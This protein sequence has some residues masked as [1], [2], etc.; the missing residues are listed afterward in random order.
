VDGILGVEKGEPTM[1]DQIRIV[2]C[3][4]VTVRDR[5]GEASKLLEHISES[6]LSL[7]AFSAVPTGTDEAQISLV[8]DEPETLREAA[9]NAGA[10]LAGPKRG[11]LIQGKDRTGALHEYHL[12]LSNAGVNVYSSSGICDGMGRFGFI[13]WVEAGDFDKA[14]SALGL[15]G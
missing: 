8:T 10:T 3:Y 13:L 5:P 2:D 14:Y 6:G 12:A 9:A 15:E 1:D 11:F 4:Y 7:T